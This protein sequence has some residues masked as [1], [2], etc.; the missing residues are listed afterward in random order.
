MAPHYLPADRAFL[1]LPR[2]SE[3]DRPAHLLPADDL[4][5]L[6][7]RIPHSRQPSAWLTSPGVHGCTYRPAYSLAGL[8]PAES[9]HGERHVD[10]DDEMARTMTALDIKEMV[11]RSKFRAGLVENR[12]LNGRL[13]RA[14]G[15]PYQTGHPLVLTVRA[16]P[17]CGRLSEIAVYSLFDLVNEHFLIRTEP[18]QSC[19]ADHHPTDAQP[20]LHVLPELARLATKTVEGEHIIVW[21]QYPVLALEAE[22]AL[23][24]TGSKKPRKEWWLGSQWIDLQVTEAIWRSGESTDDL[25]MFTPGADAADDAQILVRIVHRI[26]DSHAFIS[27]GRDRLPDPAPE[28]CPSARALHFILPAELGAGSSTEAAEP[29]SLTFP[30]HLL[31]GPTDTARL[32]SARRE[33]PQLRRWLLNNRTAAPCA[34]CGETYPAAYLR[35]AHIKRR[36]EASEGERRDLAIGMLACAF[37]CDQMFEL[38]DIFVDS[39]GVIRSRLTDEGS[40]VA[41]AAGRLVGRRCPAAIPER[42]EYFRHHRQAHGHDE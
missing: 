25:A 39:E 9:Q 10:R 33:Q 15:R 22:L 14:K 36:A 34:L 20:L 27:R 28:V 23:T 17:C 11:A 8:E 12:A 30:T 2:Y 31:E 40:A 7:L 6:G 18:G 35:A 3:A 19:P 1:D 4:P 42:A 41:A 29:W 13:I 26:S 24:S 32:G 37:G 38:G 21:G 16:T 5:A